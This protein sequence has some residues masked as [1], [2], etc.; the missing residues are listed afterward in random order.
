MTTSRSIQRPTV[1]TIV[2][3]K[4]PEV[5]LTSQDPAFNSALQRFQ[6]GVTETLDSVLMWLNSHFTLAPP[7]PSSAGNGRTVTPDLTTLVA[8]D[9]GNVI[10]SAYPITVA[11][12]SSAITANQANLV[13]T[14]IAIATNWQVESIYVSAPSPT[15]GSATLSA[16]NSNVSGWQGVPIGGVTG[17]VL[18]NAVAATP[19]STNS[20]IA[21]ITLYANTTGSWAIPSGTVYVTLYVSNCVT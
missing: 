7:I 2:P 5:Q 3:S 20:S 4:T 13:L 21:A 17:S 8:A 18:G 1:T 12:P 9:T 19:V 16:Q 14:Q 15:A 10:Q 11:I 6:D